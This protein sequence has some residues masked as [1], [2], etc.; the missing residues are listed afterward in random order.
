MRTKTEL[1][2][3][4]DKHNHHCQWVNQVSNPGVDCVSNEREETWTKGERETLS[5]E[6][7]G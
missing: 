3:E 6:E 2:W 1:E 5:V 4:I 7:E